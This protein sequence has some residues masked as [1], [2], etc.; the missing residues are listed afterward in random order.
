MKDPLVIE[1]SRMT[2]S[3]VGS[4]PDTARV[5]IFGHFEVGMI[6][7]FAGNCRICCGFTLPVSRSTCLACV[8]ST[9]PEWSFCWRS[10]RTSPHREAGSSCTACAVSRWRASSCS[11][12][13]H[14]G[15]VGSDRLE[16]MTEKRGRQRQD[17][18]RDATHRGGGP[19]RRACL[20]RVGWSRR[21][22]TG[23]SFFTMMVW[24][25]WPPAWR[26]SWPRAPAPA[27]A[28]IEPQKRW[29]VDLRL[30]DLCRWLFGQGL[31]RH[32]SARQ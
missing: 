29:G 26:Y 22:A 18:R 12:G 3:I 1:P 16:T 31:V 20:R 2:F 27:S 7:V 32:R 13:S 17:A 21:P 28:P 14:C 4:D 5:A 8:S 6:G 23:R 30:P 15:R 25:C 11:G 9:A 24:P 19:V 10:S